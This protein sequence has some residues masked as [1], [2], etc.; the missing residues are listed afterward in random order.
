LEENKIKS[1]NYYL[2]SCHRGI[3]FLVIFLIPIFTNAAKPTTNVGKKT[4]GDLSVSIVTSTANGKYAPRNVTAIWIEDNSGT[5]VK[6]LLVNAQK[7]MKYLTN[8]LSNTPEGNT[9][10]AITGATSTTFGTLAC[11]WNGRD[12]LGIPV[13]DGTYRI[14]VELAD[15]NYI[16]NFAYFTFTK[17]ISLDIQTPENKP[18]FS[19]IS[20]KWTPGKLSGK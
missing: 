15:A 7:R 19:D 11:T 16:E 13:S 3:G 5:F 4:N 17:G 2:R 20:I 12:T 8:W 9:V 10:D 18:S 6:T 14:C 1:I